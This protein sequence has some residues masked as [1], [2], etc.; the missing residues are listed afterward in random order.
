[1]AGQQTA[2]RQEQRRAHLVQRVALQPLALLESQRLIINLGL[3]H[4]EGSTGAVR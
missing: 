4:K 3:L 1:M 2:Q